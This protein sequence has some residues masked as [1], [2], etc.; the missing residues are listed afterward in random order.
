MGPSG[1]H[2]TRNPLKLYPFL[3]ISSVS[4]WFR[5]GPPVRDPFNWIVSQISIER[6]LNDN[7]DYVV[8]NGRSSYDNSFLTDELSL[9]DH[10]VEV[11]NVGFSCTPTLLPI[12]NLIG[13]KSDQGSFPRHRD[14]TPLSVQRQTKST[15]VIPSLPSWYRR[16]W[17]PFILRVRGCGDSVAATF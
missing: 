17:G 4:E 6:D 10:K 7:L 14:V 11:S 12:N 3:S 5:G 13:N 2:Q 16:Q 15:V 1:S 8:K 9:R